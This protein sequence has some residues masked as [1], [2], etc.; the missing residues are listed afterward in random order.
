MKNRTGSMPAT[1]NTVLNLSSPKPSPGK[2]LRLK[3]RSR[4]DYGKMNPRK[5]PHMTSG[6]VRRQTRPLLTNT[7]PDTTE[8]PAYG[9]NMAANQEMPGWITPPVQP[10][11]EGPIIRFE[12]LSLNMTTRSDSV[13]I[14]NTKGDF[15]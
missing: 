14:E 8:L 5:R 12:T 7:G 13:F 1:T 4:E 15:V 3:K 2:T 11:V 6:K 9:E 10:L